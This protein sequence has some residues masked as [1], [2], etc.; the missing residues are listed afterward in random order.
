MIKVEQKSHLFLFLKILNTLFSFLDYPGKLKFF[1]FSAL[2][3]F[4]QCYTNVYRKYCGAEGA[5]IGCNIA[6]ASSVEDAPFCAS[7]M[8]PCT[9]SIDVNKL[10]LLRKKLSASMISQKFM[11]V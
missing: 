3:K 8:P 1:I 11:H 6:K 9:K 5:Y 2:G 10:V 4:V 7:Q